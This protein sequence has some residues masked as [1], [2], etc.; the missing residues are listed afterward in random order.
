MYLWGVWEWGDD[1]GDVV[2]GEEVLDE[3]VYRKRR[4]G[5]Q[6]FNTTASSTHVKNVCWINNVTELEGLEN[7]IP[8]RCMLL[9]TANMAVTTFLYTMCW[10]GH[11]RVVGGSH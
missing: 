8:S 10:N 7:V 6:R 2:V 3:R 4:R 5:I 1:E 11:Q 9:T